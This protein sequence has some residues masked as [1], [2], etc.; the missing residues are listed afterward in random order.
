MID[1]I[2]L[3]YV[4][5]ACSV[6]ALILVIRHLFK[7]RVWIELRQHA[8]QVLTTIGYVKAYSKDA[9]AEIYNLDGEAKAAI[10]RV[11]TDPDSPRLRGNVEVLM[12]SNNDDAAKPRYR[13]VGYV[14]FDQNTTIDEYGYIYKQIAG[15]K[16]RELIGYLAR[17]SKPHTPTLHGERTWRSLWL[18]CTLCAYAGMPNPELDK[19]EKKKS[20]RKEKKNKQE[21]PTST[22]NPQQPTSTPIPQQ[23][24]PQT[25]T[26][27]ECPETQAPEQATNNTEQQTPILRLAARKKMEMVEKSVVEEPIAE[28]TIVEPS[29]EQSA[30]EEPIVE[31]ETVEEPTMELETTDDVVEQ[32]V[33]EPIAE[34]TEELVEESSEELV[35]ESMDEAQEASAAEEAVSAEEDD[36]VE[37]PAV[38]PFADLEDSAKTYL[39]DLRK[40][41]PSLVASIFADMVYVK[42][43]HFIMGSDPQ[44]TNDILDQDGKTRGMVEQ[45]ESPKHEVSLQDYYIGKYPINQ[46]LWTL[47]MGYNPSEV[48]DDS[49]P[50]APVNWFESQQFVLRLSYLTGVMLSLPTEAQWEYAARGGEKSQGTVFAGSNTFSEVGWSDYKHPVGMKKPNELGIYDMSGLVREWCSDL[51]GHYPDTLQVDP[52]G[53]AED[54]PLIIRNTEDRL[55]RAVRS[56]YGNETVTNRKG[57]TPELDKEFKSYGLR[58]ACLEIPKK[59]EQEDTAAVIPPKKTPRPLDPQKEP[60]LMAKCYYTGFYNSR[61]DVLPPEARACAYAMLH[62]YGF[63]QRQAE[64]HRTQPYGWRD[65]ALLSSLVYAVIYIL[66]YIVNTGVF[67]FPLVGEDILVAFMLTAFYFI[68]WAIIRFIKVDA[69][70]QGNSFQPQLDMFNKNLSIKWMNITIL[71]L[72]L[73]ATICGL[74]LMDYAD[75]DFLPLAWVIAIGTLIN[76]TLSYANRKWVIKTDISNSND[77]DDDEDDTEEVPNPSGDI[78]RTY[79]WELDS[80]YPSGKQLHG[81][82]TLYFSNSQMRDVRF[83]NPFFLQRN[84]VSYKDSVIE[85]FHFLKEHKTYLARTRYVAYVIKEL[86]AKNHL[87]PLD[88]IQFTLDFVQE[89]NITYLANKD[90]KD[91]NYLESYIAFPDEILYNKVGDYNSKAL[92]AAMLFH[93]MRYNVLYLISRTHQHAAIAV[94]VKPSDLENGYYGNLDNLKNNLI[95]FNEKSYIFCETTIDHFVLGRPYDGMKIDEFEEKILLPLME[96]DVEEQSEEELDDIQNRIYAWDLD[97]DTGNK[98]SGSFVI[99]FA[100]S[101][102]EH[103]RDINPFRSYGKDHHSYEDN[104]RSIFAYLDSNPNHTKNLRVLAEYIKTSIETA[105]LTDLDKYQFALDFVQ[106]PNIKYCIDE[107]SASI[108][109][110]AEYMRIPD[111]TLYDKEGDCD[112]KS[113]LAAA[114]FRAMGKNVLYLIST[115]L[116]HAAV[117]IECNDQWL[118]VIRPADEQ[119]VV[120]EYEGKKYIFCETTGDGYRIGHLKENESI[121]DFE[122]KISLPI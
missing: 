86:A 13:R 118:E 49:F 80:E 121:H 14:C 66:L 98:L 39:D 7:T 111:E 77:E 26:P 110:A 81:S 46:R 96:D 100:Q 93:C 122:I 64:G 69:I 104:V 114:L 62:K 68:L 32:V 45:N 1:I 51:Y 63:K 82:L 50:V 52:T 30:I 58:I 85:M 12:T 65:T 75:F 20:K 79:D 47:I 57:E 107:Q 41:Q 25:E 87:S 112:C 21:Q 97:S 70:E 4:L 116:G 109:Y 56:P 95:K 18:R 67:Q 101:E 42:G 90:N 105:K 106:E 33:E 76:M 35:E 115:K 43:G 59:A 61:K 40:Q 103:L 88:L 78:T 15:K 6:I 89:P 34:P 117:A 37:E 84:D 108:E 36:A 11:I 92:L 8:S 38:D 119:L 19:Q 5:L 74:G 113:A 23:P 27:Q 99:D 2:I 83:V 72:S 73:M 16:E 24:Q 55:C 53:P 54:S 71:I 44:P 48:K 29:I 102:I 28:S 10:G 9:S 120:C 3:L 60:V 22:P 91:V 94:E 31:V 17:P